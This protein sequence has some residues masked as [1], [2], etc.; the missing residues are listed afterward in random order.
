MVCQ[1]NSFA[2]PP[3]VDEKGLLDR[4]PP[5]HME[6]V[7]D[8]P[9]TVTASYRSQL[10]V[11]NQTGIKILARTLHR[12][13]EP[14]ASLL[15]CGSNVLAQGLSE[16]EGEL[17]NFHKIGIGK[18]A[19]QKGIGQS[20]FVGCSVPT[21]Q[22]QRAPAVLHG[23][24]NLQKLSHAASYVLQPPERK[25]G[26]RPTTAFGVANWAVTGL[27]GPEFTD[28][29][30]RLSENDPKTNISSESSSGQL[31]CDYCGCSARALR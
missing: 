2:L 10:L 30:S 13:I 23:W 22:D 31:R 25:L 27:S 12:S 29:L 14:S 19:A 4:L 8:V 20:K 26:N 11:G 21:K 9:E 3:L 24:L 18:V 16:G 1:T 28:A 17:I 7:N 5:E 6:G 15:R